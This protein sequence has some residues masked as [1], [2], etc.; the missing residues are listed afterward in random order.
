MRMHYFIFALLIF[1]NFESRASPPDSRPCVGYNWK[2]LK[3]KLADKSI[4]SRWRSECGESMASLHMAYGSADIALDYIQR[5]IKSKAPIKQLESD[6]YQAIN[7]NFQRIV[8]ALL[9]YGVSPNASE[10]GNYSPLMNSALSGHLEI[11]R[12]L[13]KAGADLNY[14]AHI[15]MNAFTIAVERGD[16]H[17]VSLLLDYGVDINKYRKV[18]HQNYLLDI[19]IKSNNVKMIELLLQLKFDLNAYDQN[20]RTPLQYA[21]EDG[22][23][24][25]MVEYLLNSGANPCHKNAKGENAL[26]LYD[27]M[28]RE[29][30]FEF[31]KTWHYRS[32]FEDA[33]H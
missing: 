3:A 18:E 29:L 27:R 25:N 26:A 32:L 13:I 30:K 20:R 12:M 15:N 10:K 14:E 33:C 16:V 19:A 22:A 24:R 6:F 28:I 4:S 5:E 2:E 7:G 21:I 23:T 17:A 31:N 9:K 8:D 1:L 11:M